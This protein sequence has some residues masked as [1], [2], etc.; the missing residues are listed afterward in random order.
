MSFLIHNLIIRYFKSD[1]LTTEIKQVQLFIFR[2][3]Y[4]LGK[5][6]IL[7]SYSTATKKKKELVRQAAHV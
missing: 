7:C 2:C 4:V 6:N 5:H 3:Q 1:I